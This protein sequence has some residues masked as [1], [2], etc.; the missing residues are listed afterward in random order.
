MFRFRNGPQRFSTRR[1]QPGTDPTTP[2]SR[3]TVEASRFPLGDPDCECK[4]LLTTVTNLCSVGE[5]LDNLP[6][7]AKELRDLYPSSET[8]SQK[9][10]PSSGPVRFTGKRKL[11]GLLTNAWIFHLTIHY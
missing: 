2:V 5:L 10:C 11:A 9:H 8:D 7:T 1:R 6:G 3:I 4:R